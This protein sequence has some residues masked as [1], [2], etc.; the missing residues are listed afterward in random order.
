[1]DARTLEPKLNR[2]EATADER[3]SPAG[4]SQQDM[5]ILDGPRNFHAEDTVTFAKP[6]AWPT[7]STPSCLRSRSTSAQT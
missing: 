7:S 5:P 4:H 3:R 6:G 1:M 2:F